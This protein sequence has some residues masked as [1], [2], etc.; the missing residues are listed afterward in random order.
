MVFREVVEGDR[1]QP[2]GYFDCQLLKTI[3]GGQGICVE[4]PKR[5][6]R[7]NKLIN[8]LPRVDWLRQRQAIL[9]QAVEK[10]FYMIQGGLI[11]CW[12][13]LIECMQDLMSH[14]VVSPS[15][16]TTRRLAVSRFAPS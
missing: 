14:F 15:V 11:P 6:G 5:R 7:K 9:R 2:R 16:W 10:T 1:D 3:V 4:R 8:R 13:K 12:I